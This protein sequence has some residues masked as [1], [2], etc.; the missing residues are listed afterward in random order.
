MIFQS[1]HADCIMCNYAVC[2]RTGLE[3]M[4]GTLW[5]FQRESSAILQ[6]HKWNAVLLTDK[7]DRITHQH[8]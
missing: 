8:I 6:L 3:I 1:V 7:A 2:Y 5:S 4:T